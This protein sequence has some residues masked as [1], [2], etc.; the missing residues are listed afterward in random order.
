M[1]KKSW[2]KV[3]V[4]IRNS[5]KSMYT[6]LQCRHVYVSTC[7]ATAFYSSI[8]HLTRLQRHVTAG[9]KG[10]VPGYKDSGVKLLSSSTTKRLI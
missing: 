10:R 4:G 2:M 5:I 6:H 9:V 3:H 8:S 1:G 7:V